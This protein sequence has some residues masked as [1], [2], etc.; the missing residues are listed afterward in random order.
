LWASE[1]PTPAGARQLLGPSALGPVRS[2]VVEAGPIR[3]SVRKPDATF[4]VRVL[5]G[6][7][8]FVSVY[9]LVGKDFFFGVLWVEMS[10]G[11]RY[12]ITRGEFP[13]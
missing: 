8:S 12:P 1:T 6:P 2:V 7:F 5:V 4:C 9:T 13:Y 10:M 3:S 11:T